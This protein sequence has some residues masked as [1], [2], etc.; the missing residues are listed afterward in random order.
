MGKRKHGLKEHMVLLYNAEHLPVL[1]GHVAFYKQQYPGQETVTKAYR[2]STPFVVG[3]YVSGSDRFVVYG[4]V[5]FLVL[6]IRRLIGEF[7]ARNRDWWVSR[8]KVVDDR[9]LGE[10][11]FLYDS[12]VMDFVVLVSTHARNLFHLVNDKSVTGK[13]IPLLNYEKEQDGDV[14]LN[15]LFDILI[16]NRYYYLDGGVI[17]DVFSEKF[18]ERSRFAEK[19][20]GYGIDLQA[21]VQGIADAI[22]EVRMRHL[23]TILRGKMKHLRP[24]SKRQDVVFLIQNVHSFSDLMKTRIPTGNYRLIEQLVFGNHTEDI[25]YKS[26]EIT[27]NPDLQRKAFDIRVEWAKRSEYDGDRGKLKSDKVTVGYES[28][29]DVVKTLFGEERLL[30]FKMPDKK[31]A[32]KKTVQEPA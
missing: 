2:S 17:R 15:E 11:D 26:P 10:M 19:F 32:A 1:Y 18:K 30:D 14:K 21:Y 7:I 27:I 9:S 31:A 28:L 3:K 20:M 29:F 4:S 12:H 23:T 13:T 16:H 6:E 25:V 24:D 22:R 8:Q 5:H